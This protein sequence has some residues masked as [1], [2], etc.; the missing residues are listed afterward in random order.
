MGDLKNF[1][2]EVRVSQN[3][4]KLSRGRGVGASMKMLS[5]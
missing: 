2:L 5:I 1:K 4:V 3:L